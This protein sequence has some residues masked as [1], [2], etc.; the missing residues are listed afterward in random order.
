MYCAIHDGASETELL[1][2]GLFT[3]ILA[4]GRV[5]VLVFFF[6]FLNIF[7]FCSLFIERLSPFFHLLITVMTANTISAL[8]DPQCL[9]TQTLTKP[10]PTHTEGHDTHQQ[11]QNAIRPILGNTGN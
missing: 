2:T 11:M 1:G 8:F 9:W 3:G 7:L 6:F 10:H 5:S 4:Q